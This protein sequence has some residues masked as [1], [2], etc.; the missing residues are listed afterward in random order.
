MEADT[1]TGCA[2][3]PRQATPSLR[4]ASTSSRCGSAGTGSGCSTARR[5]SEWSSSQ[6]EPPPAPSRPAASGPRQQTLTS[7][8]IEILTSADID[9]NVWLPE[10]DTRLPLDGRGLAGGW[11]GLPQV[12]PPVSASR[13]RPARIW[14]ELLGARRTGL[15]VHHHGRGGGAGP[16]AGRVRALLPLGLRANKSNMERLLQYSHHRLRE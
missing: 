5:G 4:T 14:R 16:S 3:T 15:L 13:A 12:R 10:P 2:R 9:V 8:V 1:P 6:T 7:L 11:P